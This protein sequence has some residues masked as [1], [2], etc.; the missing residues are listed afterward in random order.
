MFY[1]LCI[2]IF[3][4]S[5][6]ADMKIGRNNVSKKQFG[7]KLGINS[8]WEIVMEIFIVRVLNLVGK[9]KRL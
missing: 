3:I 2:G 8:A 4:S 7:M 5:F 9:K 1:G 6:I